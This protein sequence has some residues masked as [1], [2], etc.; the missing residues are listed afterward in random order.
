MTMNNVQTK[1]DLPWGSVEPDFLVVTGSRMYGY[2]NDESD[3]DIRGVAIEPPDYL[4]GRKKFNQAIRDNNEDVTI[5]GFQKFLNL[6]CIESPNVY[7]LLFATPNN[8]ILCSAKMQYLLNNKK[9]FISKEAIKPILGYADGELKAAFAD[10]SNIKWKRAAHTCRLLFQAIELLKYGYINYPLSIAG[11]L[12]EI[13]DGLHPKEFIYSS[14]YS[15]K[16]KID[17]LMSKSNIPEKKN[18][19]SIDVL[20]Y[21]IVGNSIIE[22]LNKHRMVTNVME[23]NCNISHVFIK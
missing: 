9:F 10:L 5:W 1:H 15:W 18:M 22:L 17:L 2:A 19:E 8:I 20:Y 12:K 16:N 14:V 23:N 6:I 11:M 3:W 7:E 4:L 13:R 21:E